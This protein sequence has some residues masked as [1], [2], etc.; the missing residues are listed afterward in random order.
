MLLLIA[1]VILGCSVVLRRFN[2]ANCSKTGFC[3]QTRKIGSYK[4]ENLPYKLNLLIIV[5]NLPI[6]LAVIKFAVRENI[7]QHNTISSLPNNF[8]IGYIK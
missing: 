7:Y 3:S 8:V 5:W 6:G 4:A 2:H 1:N